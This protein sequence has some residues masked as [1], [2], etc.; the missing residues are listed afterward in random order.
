VRVVAGFAQAASI[1]P[2]AL[3]R[4]VRERASAAEEP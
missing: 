1:T 2:D 4:A 3:E